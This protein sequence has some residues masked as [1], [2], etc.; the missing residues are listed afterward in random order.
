MTVSTFYRLAVFVSITLGATGA[1][2]Q[3]RAVNPTVLLP[4]LQAEYALH[5]DDYLLLGL[6]GPVSTTST[7][8]LEQVGL[9]VGYEHFWNTSWSGGGTLGINTYGQGRLTGGDAGKLYTDVAPEAFARHWNTF[10]AF[11]FRQRLGLTYLIPGSRGGDSRALTSLRLDLDRLIPVGNGAVALRPRLAY[12]ATAYLRFQR[13]EATQPKERFLDF[14]YARAEVG[15]RVSN[16]FDFTPWFG[17]QS[18]YVFALAQTNPMGQVTT[19]AGR[20]NLV[21][22]VVGL[23]ARF[24]LFKGKTVFERRQLPTQH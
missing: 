24:T 13:D 19:P 22:P 7:G 12:E 9:L 23:D 6:R 10:G 2:A 3:R 8:G 5:G 16:H 11:N 21:T 1:V 20:L 18:T 4:T 14:G 17:Y 15:V